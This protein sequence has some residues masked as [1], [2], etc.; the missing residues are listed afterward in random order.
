MNPFRTGKLVLFQVEYNRE[1]HYFE[2]V[3][4]LLIG[5][6]GGLYGEYVLRFN[7]QVQRFRKKYLANY[8]VQEAVI[9]AS[10]TAMI[11]YFNRFLRLDMTET[12]ELLFQQ[13][14]GASDN[15]VLC[16][17]RMQ[18]SMAGAL[19]IATA[20][21]FVLVIL[22][23][24]CKVPAGI[25]IPSMAVGATFGRMVGILVKAIQTAFPSWN[26]FSS[27]T[28]DA[29]CITPGTYAMLGAAAA[30]AGVTRITV[31]VVVIMF[32]LTGAL[33]YILPIMLVV[34]TAK[35]VADLNGKGGVADRSIKFNG[36]PFLDP[37]DH[38]FGINVGSMMTT[39][40]DVLFADG[41]RYN[42]VESIVAQGTY[43][44]FPVVANAQNCTVLG[45]MERA[46]LR[47]ALRQAQATSTLHKDSMCTF[48]PKSTDVYAL[49][50]ARAIDSQLLPEWLSSTPDTLD[51]PEEGME[52]ETGPVD[53]GAWVDP[54]PLIVQPQ[55]D[56]E[57]VSDMFKRLGPRVILVCSNGILEGIV[58]IKDLLRHIARQ[59]REEMNDSG[60]A[61]VSMDTRADT[62]FMIGTGV[63]EEALENLW[64]NAC[65]LAGRFPWGERYT[66]VPGHVPLTSVTTIY[67]DR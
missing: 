30:L 40:T 1:W 44:G 20:L 59:E 39:N 7:L 49:T 42:E 31:A 27:C 33:T 67:A 36:Y 9:L 23:Y 61:D 55:L 56:L 2:I 57:V 21:R 45:Y 63:L 22:S 48:H 41:M 47:F 16:Q 58:T 8:G 18:W 43:R 6:M 35:L 19:L 28:T 34:G 52:V 66:Q 15:E 53:L 38:T 64:H 5:I 14:D 11:C 4:F 12:L 60:A 13:C 37:E 46:Q 25:F 29:P 10:V 62:G 32:E 65:S 26:V 54:A 50:S 51:V 24:G 3:F 17:S